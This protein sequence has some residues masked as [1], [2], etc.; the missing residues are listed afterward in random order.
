MKDLFNK[1]ANSLAGTAQGAKDAISD[2]ASEAAQLGRDAAFNV[3]RTAITM[4]DNAVNSANGVAGA[5]AKLYHSVT[6]TI[7]TMIDVG[8]VVAAIAAPVP[9]AIGVCLL[10]LLEAQLKN[11]SRRIDSA[12][13]AERGRR[14]F[15]RVTGLLKKHGQIPESAALRTDLIT[16]TINSRT[17]EV[18]G[19]VLKGEFKGWDLSALS[20]EQIARMLEFAPDNDT[21][22][23]LEAYQTLRVARDD[24]Q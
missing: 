14:K 17:G 16:M 22:S 19:K 2:K 3:E 4:R 13:A 1:A 5:T 6:G 23:I 10:W 11:E 9:V 18:T 24:P 12:V 15:E 7:S 21:R 8:I 20:M